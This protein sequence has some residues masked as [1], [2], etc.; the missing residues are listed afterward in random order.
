MN[1]ALRPASLNLISICTGGG[2]LDLGVEL[3]I[4][5]ARSVCLVEREAFGVS[6]LV[7]AMR[8]GLLA[9]APVWSD[10]RTF[11]GRAWRGSVDGLI[12]GIPCQPHS[13]AG[14]RLERED[15]RDLWSTARRIIV[16]SGAWFVLIENVAGMLSSGGAERVYGDLGRLGF[17]REVGLFTAS[18]VGASHERERTFILGVADHRGLGRGAGQRH[19]HARQSDAKGSRAGL[20][21]ADRAGPPQHPCERCNAGPELSTS[22][23]GGR[24]VDDASIARSG[25]IPI[26]PWRQVET[27]AHLDR[28]SYGASGA[29]R[30]MADP[31]GIEQAARGSHDR[32]ITGI[33]KREGG[34]NDGAALSG[35]S[36]SPRGLF[37]PGPNDTSE[38]RR[39]LED[40]PELEPAFRRVA[41]GLAS[42]LDTARVDRLRMLGNGVVP[43]QAAYAIR[44]LATRLASR[45]SA[46]ATRLVRM[47]NHQEETQ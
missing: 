27:G 4:P 16:Q 15:P 14:K 29:D 32:E 6:Q 22:E 18:E 40:R 30:E 5:C 36:G 12:G 8:Q 35:G 20:A 17:A 46:G 26:L 39:A 13:L 24:P 21:D 10:A 3:A 31:D 44:T 37:P 33:S 2:G 28:A 43:L 45:G 47:M 38:W 41:D 9:Q 19:L 1:V 25:G 7:S 23:R 42:R 11:D 34:P